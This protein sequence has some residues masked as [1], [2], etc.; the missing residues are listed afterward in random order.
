MASAAELWQVHSTL[1]LSLR[2]A[3]SV[4]LE[5]ESSPIHDMIADSVISVIVQIASNPLQFNA[6]AAEKS[7]SEL[8][9]ER[10]LKV[11]DIFSAR[12]GVSAVS[13]DLDVCCIISSQ[14]L[15]LLE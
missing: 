10:F 5:W 9:R 4:L 11:R 8:G 15:I 6:V 1:V 7:E 12:F 13:V 3:K 14:V 2:S